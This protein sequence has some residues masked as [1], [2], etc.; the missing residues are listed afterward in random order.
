MDSNK[1]NQIDLEREALPVMAFFFQDS[2]NFLGIYSSA[3]AL[4]GVLELAPKI[5]TPTLILHGENDANTSIEG[6]RELA[7]LLPNAT[8]KSYAGLGHSLGVAKSVT[9]DDFRPMEA[10]PLADLPNWINKH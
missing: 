8:L 2:P 4:P 5:K 7:Q 10:A 6:A 9:D 3:L 1:D